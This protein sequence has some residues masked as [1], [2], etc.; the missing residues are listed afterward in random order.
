VQVCSVT[1]VSVKKKELVV[2]ASILIWG[3]VFGC[4]SK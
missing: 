1:E 3:K 2:A 4:K